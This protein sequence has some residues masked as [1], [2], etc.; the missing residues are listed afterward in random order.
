MKSEVLTNSDATRFR[1]VSITQASSWSFI[2]QRSPRSTGSSSCFMSSSTFPDP[3][4]TLREIFRVL[5]PGG[6]L[7]VETPS[8]DTLTFKLLGRRERSISC[9]GY[10]FFFFTTTS[11]KNAYTRAG[12]TLVKLS[13]VGRTLTLDRLAYNL[14]VPLSSRAPSTRRGGSVCT[15]DTSPELTR[16]AK[17]PGVTKVRKR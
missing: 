12:F 6:H 1:A 13:Y 17:S 14:G 4:G 7:V 11:L 10:I 8:Y 2:R 15:S 9:D 16:H 3:V 5:R